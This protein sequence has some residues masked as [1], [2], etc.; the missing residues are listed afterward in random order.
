MAD[1]SVRRVAVRAFHNFQ[2]HQLTD[3]AAALTYYA[4][5]S[6]F[7][8]IL[9]ALTLLGALGDHTTVARATT[10]IVKHGADPTTARAVNGALRTLVDGSS[11]ELGIAVIVSIVLGINAVSGAFGASGRA[12]NRIFGYQE[13]R[14]FVHRRLTNMAIAVV[15]IVLIVVVLGSMFLGGQVADDLFGT[16]GIGS[17]AAAIWSVAR[18]PIAILAAM[19]L[20]ALV[21]AYA[22]D[23]PQRAIRWLSPGAVAG[24]FVW[25]ATSIGFFLYVKNFSHYGA[26]Y[27]AAG[28]VIV[29]LLWLWLSACAFLLGAEL[30]A[31]LDRL[32]EE[33][34]EAEPDAPSAPAGARTAPPG[35]DT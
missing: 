34:L 8:G 31:E 24:V 30:N 22:P 6:L 17:T 3:S 27:G 1:D 32:T 19:L 33:V 18:F 7:P 25:I 2:H 9:L 29:L 15:V 26:A 5:M 16:I 12:L 14:G 13:D 10:Y 23:V 28:A 35:P 11:K 4:V 20:Y 21:Y